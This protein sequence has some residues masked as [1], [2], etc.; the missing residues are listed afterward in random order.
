MNKLIE[1]TI[2]NNFSIVNDNINK[3]IRDYLISQDIE[4]FEY[5]KDENYNLIIAMIYEW[6]EE[7]DIEAL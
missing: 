4:D 3:A 1:I 6:L 7:N 5:D 2:L